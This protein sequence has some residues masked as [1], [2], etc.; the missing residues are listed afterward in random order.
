MD[1][2]AYLVGTVNG[3]NSDDYEVECFNDEDINILYQFGI[4]NNTIRYSSAID[5]EKYNNLNLK[6]G[7]K[8]KLGIINN[9][10]QIKVDI[11]ERIQTYE[12]RTLDKY[13]DILLKHNKVNHMVPE[14]MAE[15]DQIPIN[16]G[17]KEE[18]LYD[19]I[20]SN[21]QDGEVFTDNPNY[22]VEANNFN[23]Y[24]NAGHILFSIE[25]DNTMSGI[26]NR[27]KFVFP[28]E[29]DTDREAFLDFCDRLQAIRTVKYPKID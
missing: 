28:F 27:V 19:D 21:I 5:A 18:I 6:D 12:R 4:K 2:E 22:R 9:D 20:S 24:D 26:S 1:Y 17:D 15:S 29:N 23:I 3:I 8:V 13:L 14:I 11:I 16:F 7:V 10:G 25:S